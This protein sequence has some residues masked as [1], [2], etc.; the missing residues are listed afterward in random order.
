MSTQTNREAE[1][2][3]LRLIG[4]SDL[5]G[6]GDGMQLMLKD[7]YLFVGHV[8]GKMGTTVL[9]VSNPRDP[10]VVQQLEIPP[11]T[12]SHKVQIVDDICAHAGL[13]SSFH[14]AGGDVG[15]LAV[16]EQADDGDNS[17]DYQNF[18]HGEFTVRLR[19]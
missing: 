13:Q 2:W 8:L 4:H 3:N 10:R 18:L 12:H 1:A 19:I 6:H 5:A 11:Y 7:E 17:D 16:G 15:T 14:Q 9:D